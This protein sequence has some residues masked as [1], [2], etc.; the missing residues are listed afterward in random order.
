MAGAALQQAAHLVHLQHQVFAKAPKRPA[1]QYVQHQKQAKKPHAVH[2]QHA[3]NLP[4]GIAEAQDERRGDAHG[5]VERQHGLRVR[6]TQAFADAA[7]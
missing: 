4:Q 2:R 7:P 3:G 1:L 6:K 5:G